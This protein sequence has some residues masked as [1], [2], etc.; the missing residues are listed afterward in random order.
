MKLELLIESIFR[1]E[2]QTYLAKFSDHRLVMSLNQ[3]V[4]D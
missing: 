1:E 4:S 2:C 3:E